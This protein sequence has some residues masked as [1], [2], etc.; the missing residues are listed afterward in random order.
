M[1]RKLRTNLVWLVML[2]LSVGACRPAPVPTP[3]PSPSPTDLGGREIIWAVDNA[4]PP[5]SYLDKEGKA[6][7]FDYD[8]AEEICKRANC[9][10]VFVEFAWDGIFEAA[11]AGEFDISM[12]GCTLSLERAKVVDFSDPIHE[13][14][15]V[16]LVRADETLITDE[17]TL[18]ESDR[19][20]GTRTGTTNEITAIRRF[21]ERRVILY[22]AFELS[23]VA[24]LSGDVDAVLIDEMAAV[25]FQR[26]H[27]GK[28]KIAFRITGGELLA[29]FMPPGSPIQPAVNQALNEMWADGTM[30]ALID[31]WFTA[32]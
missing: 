16:I 27:P 26:E 10:P 19:R 23:V 13:Y 29:L 3:A 7:G 20:V 30:Q 28:M 25:G 12:S 11:R 14:G 4:Y 6:V 9:R 31:E 24:L 18:L 32:K 1:K 2:S 5:F 22:E 21:G 15:Q 17:E 8:L